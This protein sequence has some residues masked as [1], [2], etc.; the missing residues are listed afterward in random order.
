M[1]IIHR[2]IFI[3]PGGHVAKRS[4]IKQFPTPKSRLKQVA[5]AFTAIQTAAADSGLGRY[6]S[7]SVFGFKGLV[8][9]STV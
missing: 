5:I 2:I 7:G 1:G 9:V 3:R 6:I 4:G 8:G